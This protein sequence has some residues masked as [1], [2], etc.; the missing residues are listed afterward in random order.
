[1]TAPAPLGEQ[2]AQW[3]HV[4]GQR[5]DLTP[6][7]IDELTDRLRDTVDDLS[8]RGL[9]SDEAFLIAARRVAAQHPGTQAIAAGHAD[10]MWKQL[11][12]SGPAPTGDSTRSPC[13]AMML[14]FAAV[15]GVMVA[16]PFHI[17]WLWEESWSFPSW[18]LPV[19]TMV[20]LVATMAVW[21]WWQ[22]RP[23]PMAAAAI[24]LSALVAVSL[25]GVLYPFDSP[26]MTLP[27]FLLHSPIVLWFVLG[28]SYL[29]R[30]WRRVDRWMDYVRFTGE[31]II[32]LVLIAF[33]GG[34][35]LGLTSSIFS[36]VGVDIIEFALRWIIPLGAGGALVVSA[37]LVDNKKGAV[38]NIAPVLT[39]VFTPLFTLVMLAFLTVLA[40][41]GNP[42]E[43]DRG[44]LIAVDLLLVV[45]LALLVFSISARPSDTRP[46]LQDWVSV[47]LLISALAVDAVVGYAIAGRI[48]EHGVSAN[49]LA[50]VGENLLLAVNL[51]VSAWLYVGFL[52]GKRDFG[53]L[54]RWQMR[55][56]PVI[57]LWAAVVALGFPLFFNFG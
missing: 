53:S 37:W 45:V 7:D 1:M 9:S 10:T 34:V 57:A 15:A 47:A 43:A 8:R 35:L 42:V 27:L 46:R 50:A 49:K 11:L 56:L 36:L 4:L 13:L 38:E 28:A 26:W 20:G 30:D 6:R 24:T 21:F 23:V 41:T 16:V 18:V 19:I 29:G 17:L 55:Y 39:G 22:R 2:L 51:A 31:L 25:A 54:E 48:F 40:I 44:L 5:A 12:V 33:G 52:R 32:Y 3:R 14:V